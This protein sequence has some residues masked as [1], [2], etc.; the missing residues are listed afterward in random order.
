MK[1]THNLINYYCYLKQRKYSWIAFLLLFL[2]TITLIKM[3]LYNKSRNTEISFRF[4]Y[5]QIRRYEI[6]QEASVSQEI[7]KKENRLTNISNTKM[8]FSYKTFEQG[9]K[10]RNVWVEFDSFT[11][12]NKYDRNFL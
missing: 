8:R 3:S 4:P 6:S 12:N 11:L 1:I 9:K 5:N 2:F 10:G 7:G